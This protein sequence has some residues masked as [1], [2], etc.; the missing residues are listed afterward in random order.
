MRLSLQLEALFAAGRKTSLREIL[1]STGHKGPALALAAASILPMLPLPI[2]G[3]F[4][5][6]MVPL[7]LELVFPKLV[8][9]PGF[10]LDK[11][12]S[13]DTSSRAWRWGLAGLRRTEAVMRPRLPSFAKSRL[14]TWVTF[15]LVLACCAS[16][17]I[18]F[19][20]TNGVPS[21]GVL[22][23]CL[24]IVEEDGLAVLAGWLVAAAGLALAVV[25]LYGAFWA[26]GDALGAVWSLAGG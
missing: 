3:V 7:A 17:A 6:V 20:G 25:I 19:P 13:L 22:L 18:P 1:A 23:M 21:F 5:L 15:A 26:G 16:I 8:S 11:P 24:G 14:A 9:L 4:G 12:L 10:V 2:V